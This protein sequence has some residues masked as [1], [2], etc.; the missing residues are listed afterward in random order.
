LPLAFAKA[1][2]FSTRALASFWD[3]RMPDAKTSPRTKQSD[4]AAANIL[5]IDLPPGRVVSVMTG[6]VSGLNHNDEK[7]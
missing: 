4:N 3:A 1:A 5:F 7:A 2:A 6:S